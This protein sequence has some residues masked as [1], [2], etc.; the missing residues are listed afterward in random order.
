MKIVILFGTESGTAEFVA[1]DVADRLADVAETFVSD[2]AE[3]SV[4]D[5]SAENLYLVV[6][7]TYGDGE[8]PASALPFL[9]ALDADAPD[10]DGLRYAVFGMGDSS[11]EETYSQGSEIV[12]AKFTELGAIRVGEYGRHDAAGRD[13]AG[14]VAVAWVDGIMAVAMLSASGRA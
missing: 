9:E 6:C 3:Y 12:D 7:S 4:S 11:Y 5:L 2:L 10:L 14:D 1:G 8:P 13:V